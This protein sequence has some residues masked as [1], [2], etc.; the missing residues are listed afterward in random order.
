MRVLLPVLLLVLAAGPVRAEEDLPM[1]LREIGFD[2]RLGETIPLD[3]RFTHDRGHSV[4]LG[5]LVTERP[6]LLALV[7]YDCPMLCNMVLN[8]LVASLRPLKFDAGQEFD[9]VVVSFDPTEDPELAAAKKAN[10]LKTY[11]REGADDAWHFLTGTQA[12]ITRLTEAVGFRYQFDEDTGEYAHA[13]GLS[14]LTPSGRIARTLYGIDYAPKDVRFALME[15]SEERLGS[16]VDQVLLYCFRYDPATGRYGAVVMNIVRIAAILTVGAMVG[17]WLFMW[18]RER[19]R[20]R[21]AGG[22]A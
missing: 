13:A 12:E 19:R 3:A 4:T 16:V 18:R 21:P 8:G 22:V 15:A 7:Y 1:P 6:V 5:E 2:Q 14:V 17:F 9:V 20:L 10:Y 11:N